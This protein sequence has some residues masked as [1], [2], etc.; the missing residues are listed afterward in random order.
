MIEPELLSR[1]PVIAGL[2][3]F[4]ERAGVYALD[5]VLPHFGNQL[6]EYRGHF[7][8]MSEPRYLLYKRERTCVRCGIE[9]LYFALERN[10]KR[11]VVGTEQ[12]MSRLGTHCAPRPVFGW[13]PDEG[14][15]WHFNLYGFTAE[16]KEMMLTNDHIIPKALGGADSQENLQCMCW[17]CNN[18]K[19]CKI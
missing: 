3:P 8:D 6:Q 19:G 10:L 13:V 11:I 2:T 9:G 16:G 4:Y 12:K 7:V 5:D 1:I 14:S 15:L 18:K 17:R